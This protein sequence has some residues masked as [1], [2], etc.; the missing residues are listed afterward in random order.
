MQL[1]APIPFGFPNN[2]GSFQFVPVHTVNSY[3]FNNSQIAMNPGNG[4]GSGMFPYQ[5]IVPVLAAQSPN[6][7]NKTSSI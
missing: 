4:G 5:Q 7:A 1:G 3:N 2:S 6:D